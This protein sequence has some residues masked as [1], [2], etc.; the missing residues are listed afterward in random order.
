VLGELIDRIR[1]ALM[2]RLKRD[3]CR[4]GSPWPGRTGCRTLT[5]GGNCVVLDADELWPVDR[6]AEWHPP[7]AVSS[8]A[9]GRWSGRC[10]SVFPS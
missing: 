7:A 4:S 5:P 6:V 3:S 9:L 1:E 10:R 2:R 8:V